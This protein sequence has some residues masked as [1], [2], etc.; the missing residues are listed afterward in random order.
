MQLFASAKDAKEYLISKILAQANQDGIS[1]SEL[2][3]KMLYFSETG[4]TLQN[5]TSVSQ[6]FDRTYDQDEY[7]RKMRQVIRRIDGQ[8]ASGRDKSDWNEAVRCLRDED[9]YLLVLI[10]GASSEPTKMSRWETIRLIVAGV[11]V[12][13]VFFPALAFLET[14]ISNPA[15]AKG[16]GEGL[17]LALVLL[18]VFLANRKRRSSA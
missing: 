8:P 6:E 17:F 15:I 1:L 14:H 10:D 12:V 5:M 2:E 9:H 4:W 7:E 16:I 3:R 18:V 13:A 11:V